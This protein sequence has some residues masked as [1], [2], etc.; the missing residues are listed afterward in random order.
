MNSSQLSHTLV[1]NI[2]WINNIWMSDN[3]S[4]HFRDWEEISMNILHEWICK[5]SKIGS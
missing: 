3:E 5:I 2:H 4:G 1:K